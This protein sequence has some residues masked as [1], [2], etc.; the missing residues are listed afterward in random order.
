MWRAC[1][2]LVNV[3]VNGAEAEN[4]YPSELL[5][6]V[7]S[8]LNHGRVVVSEVPVEL[9]PGGEK[10]GAVYRNCSLTGNVIDLDLVFNLALCIDADHL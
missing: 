4:S 7:D 3:R 9:C 10:N 1:K 2:P 8:L 6:F 5:D